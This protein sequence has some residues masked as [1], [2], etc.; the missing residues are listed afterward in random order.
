V[1][2]YRTNDGTRKILRETKLSPGMT[3]KPGGAGFRIKV[4]RRENQAIR[5]QRNTSVRPTRQ[6]QRIRLAE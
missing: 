2:S 1:R 6:A 3:L 4:E 5:G